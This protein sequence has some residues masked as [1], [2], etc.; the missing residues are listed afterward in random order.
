MT[1]IGSPVLEMKVYYKD[2]E[3]CYNLGE[4]KKEKNSYKSAPNPKIF[5]T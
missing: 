1:L 4:R 3:R 2:R 5:C